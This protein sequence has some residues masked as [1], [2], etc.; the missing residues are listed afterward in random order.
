MCFKVEVKKK[1][2]ALFSQ[3]LLLSPTSAVPRRRFT[4]SGPFLVLRQMAKSLTSQAR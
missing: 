3:S 4:T 2:F 1:I